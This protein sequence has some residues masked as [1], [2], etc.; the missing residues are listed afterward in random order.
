MILEHLLATFV[1]RSPSSGCQMLVGNENLKF[2]INV[3]LIV[4]DTGT[5]MKW[6]VIIE[7]ANDLHDGVISDNAQLHKSNSIIVL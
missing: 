6:Y 2:C 1:E 3:T 5:S 4:S 7:N